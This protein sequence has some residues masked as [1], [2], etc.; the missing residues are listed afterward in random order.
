MSWFD[1]LKNI[2]ISSQRTSSRDYVN[3]DDDE[4]DCLAWFTKLYQL[5]Q[6]DEVIERELYI[7]DYREYTNEK[8]WCP[9][10][11]NIKFERTTNFMQ[12]GVQKLRFTSTVILSGER[13]EFECYVDVPEP[14]S[15]LEPFSNDVDYT[16][17]F[18][19]YSTSERIET[20]FFQSATTEKRYSYYSMYDQNR[21]LQLER[22]KKIAE[23]VLKYIKEA[24]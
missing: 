3:P 15:R 19:I 14:S 21:K 17:F 13:V 2:Q 9:L 8:L 5:M 1:I 24:L 23:K 4:E 7:E 12:P 20:E 11:N 16:M 18:S 22:F 10:K 6:G